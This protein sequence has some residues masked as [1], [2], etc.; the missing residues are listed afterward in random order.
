MKYYRHIPKVLA[1]STVALLLAGCRSEVS[2]AENSNQQAVSVPA[3]A[4]S[5]DEPAFSL[6]L[7]KTGSYSAGNSGTLM[8][9]LKAKAPHHVNQEY[10]HKF[11]LKPVDGISFPNPTLARDA[12]TVE[13]MAIVLR[14]PLKPTRTGIFKVEGDFAFS[15]CT[16]DRCLIEKRTLASEI[17]VR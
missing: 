17:E 15:L 16:A 11:K 3:A 8:L 7:S 12:M 1:L 2:A 13:P 14:V 9:E 5:F 4:P 10:P 6:T